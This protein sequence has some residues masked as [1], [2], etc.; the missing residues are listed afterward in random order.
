MNIDW[1]SLP[2][3]RS[4]VA[5]RVATL[6]AIHATFEPPPQLSVGIRR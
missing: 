3:D 6:C 5:E 2:D 1:P 4:A